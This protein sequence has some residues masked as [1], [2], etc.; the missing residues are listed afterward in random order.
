MKEM[1]RG[2]IAKIFVDQNCKIKMLHF[3]DVDDAMPLYVVH[4][5]LEMYSILWNQNIKLQNLHQSEVF[6]PKTRAFAFLW[7]S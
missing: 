4:F 2:K 7:G 1:F 6:A 3:T 5:L